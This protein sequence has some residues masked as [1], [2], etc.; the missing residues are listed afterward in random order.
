MLC[1]PQA[2]SPLIEHWL[3][4][5]R[6]VTSFALHMVGIP[7]TVLG[8][9][10]LP[11]SLPAASWAIAGLSLGLF[12]LGFLLQFLGHFLEGTDPGEIIALKRRLGLPYVEFPTGRSRRTDHERI[13]ERSRE[14]QPV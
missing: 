10:M 14:E 4:R 2:P 13:A 7:L 12:I 8:A 11:I 9:L 1:P 3:E 6:G 5:H